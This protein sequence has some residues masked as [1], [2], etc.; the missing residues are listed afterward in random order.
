MSAPEQTSA[1]KEVAGVPADDPGAGEAR[2]D[3][4][5]HGDDVMTVDELLDDE[6][7]DLAGAE[8]DV[9]GHDAL[10]QAS[11]A[12]ELTVTLCS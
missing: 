5:V 9:A 6:V 11:A 4:A 8:H 12:K 2:R 1:V 7:A 10:F 3:L